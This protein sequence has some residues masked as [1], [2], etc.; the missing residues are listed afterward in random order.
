MNRTSYWRA[1]T[2]GFGMVLAAGAANAA[3]LTHS[4]QDWTGPV[5]PA[6]GPLAAGGAVGSFFID[7][8]VDY[9]F[10]NV[11]GVFSD[12]PLALCGINA[13]G[14]CD[15]LTAVDGRIV[16]AGTLDQGLTSFLNVE[17]GFADDG[18]LT[19]EVFDLSMTLITSVLNG[20]PLGP[21]GRTTMTIDRLG[22]FDIAFFR[23]SGGDTWGLDTLS[24]EAPI[25]AAVS[26]PFTSLLLGLGLAGLALRG[27]AKA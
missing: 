27:R 1:A 25:A 9:T 15:L 7:K 20:P 17:A 18:T 8:G 19:L 12:P 14:D 23:V 6:F 21:E 4:A 2:L 16:V 5:T 11:E 13:D 3:L 10:G 24:L 22:I 26:E